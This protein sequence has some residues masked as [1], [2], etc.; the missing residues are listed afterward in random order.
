MDVLLEQHLWMCCLSSIY[1][2]VASAA[3]LLTLIEASRAALLSPYPLFH[4]SPLPLPS[5]PPALTLQLTDIHG[6]A[7]R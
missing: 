1:E 2:C 5:V 3:S 7:H 4:P 6:C